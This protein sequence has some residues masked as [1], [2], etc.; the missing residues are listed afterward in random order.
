[1]IAM[2]SVRVMQMPIHQIIDVVAM[3]HRFMSATW[4]MLV[5]RLVTRTGVRHTG[6][7]IRPRHLNYTFVVV[8][9]VRL[10]QVTVVNIVHMISMLDRR[11]SAT[12]SMLVRMVLVY[13][14]CHSLLL[15]LSLFARRQSLAR[16]R[17]RIE[18][19]VRNVLIR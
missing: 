18:N 9:L 6:R 16:M 12:S 7:R 11:V 15:F 4:T 2:I 5:S 17:E 10:V 3:R 13:M 1:M 8:P 19:Q 14:M